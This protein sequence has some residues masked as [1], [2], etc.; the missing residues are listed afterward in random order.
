MPFSIS[1]E[2]IWVV[3]TNEGGEV[4]VLGL[5]ILVGTYLPYHRTVGVGTTTT[6]LVK[7]DGF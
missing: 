5:T 1:A 4:F 6:S 7:V 3:D 2:Q